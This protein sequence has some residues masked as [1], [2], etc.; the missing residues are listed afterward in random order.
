MSDRRDRAKHR[1]AGALEGWGWWQSQHRGRESKQEG[2]GLSEM[3]I[4]L[5]TQ[6]ELVLDDPCGYVCMSVSL[7]SYAL[8]SPVGEVGSWSWGLRFWE[9]DQFS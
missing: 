6:N 1:Q 4:S 5:P 7:S 8:L 3:G 9:Q 2:G